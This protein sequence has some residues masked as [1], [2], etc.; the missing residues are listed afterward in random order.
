MLL[1]PSEEQTWSIYNT[2]DNKFLGTKLFVP[3]NK[4][5]SGSSQGWLVAVN[6]DW[7]V[8]LYKPYSM[9]KGGNNIDTNI[10]LPCLFP[11]DLE[12]FF[13]PDGIIDYAE[14]YDY[15][16]EK[17]LLT[18]D[19]LTNPN[20]C[21]IVV[22]F[23]EMQELAI[24]RIAKDTTW[25][26]INGY[27][28]DNKQIMLEIK[29]IC[30]HNNQIYAVDVHGVLRS[31]DVTN[32]CNPTVNLVAP[33]RASDHSSVKR[34]L[35]ESYG[36]KLLQ[37][38]RH[39]SW[40]NEDDGRETKRF[41]VFRLDFD[42]AKWIKIKSL[43]DVSLFL[44]DNSSISV[45]ASNFIGC[46]PDSIYFTHD[47]DDTDVLGQNV[48][49]CDVDW[50]R[51]NRRVDLSGKMQIEIN[52]WSRRRFCIV[53]GDVGADEGDYMKWYL[54][55]TRKFV[56]R[57]LRLSVEFQRAIAGLREIT[58]IADS[59]STEGLDPQQ[60]ELVR[61]VG[62]TAHECLR[63][64]VGDPAIVDFCPQVDVGK[65]I[66][67]KEMV[68]R[69]S[70]E[71][72]LRKDELMP[73]P[74]N[75][76]SKDRNFHFCN[77]EQEELQDE[78]QVE[79]YSKCN[80]EQ[81]DTQNLQDGMAVD[82][83][84]TPNIEQEDIP[85]LPF[86]KS[87]PIWQIIESMDVF[88]QLPQTPH[89]RPLVKCKETKREGIAIGKMITFASSIE[90]VSELKEDDSGESFDSVIEE[91]VKL[92][93]FGFD[94]KAS[95]LEKLQD[96]SKVV[97]TQITECKGG[98]NKIDG[99]V[100]EIIKKIKILEEKR[101]M[102]MSESMERGSKFSKLLLEAAAINEDI[103]TTRRSLRSLFTCDDW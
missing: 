14:V 66:R 53:Q 101:S 59:F 55:I 75:V 87:S 26:K 51:K 57:P 78:V 88:S 63:K 70:T 25:T 86:V 23:G 13:D 17:A 44:G 97:E 99:E 62:C 7:T 89:F 67:G 11:P 27:D 20:E 48:M 64:Q 29:D 74:Y 56:E 60:V 43:G 84:C 9:V 91:L 96:E 40:R 81:D 47:I 12:G 38:E 71:S 2:L 35:V 31:F 36:G 8:T 102:P 34:Y 5:F 69:K 49:I 52:E 92:E 98:R 77:D 95:N 65:G 61:R 42:R 83:V 82:V 3:Y 19:P 6:K 4:R 22:I 15:H 18:A 16:I 68:I 33:R 21:M 46:E 39:L 24:F 58:L 76:A 90:K 54:K 93:E 85:N 37:V 1:I 94:I 72:L 45:L 73:L 103:L 30:H 50:N 10:L 100:D 79:T 80:I 32:P 41:R 28:H